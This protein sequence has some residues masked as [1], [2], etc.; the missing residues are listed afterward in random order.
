[1][2]A[3]VILAGMVIAPN[4][5]P[6]AFLGLFQLLFGSL[7]L[8][9]ALRRAPVTIRFTHEPWPNQRFIKTSLFVLGLLMVMFSI[10]GFYSGGR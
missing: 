1:V 9:L 5:P 4:N 2:K 3:G 8:L 6:S 7:L 10:L